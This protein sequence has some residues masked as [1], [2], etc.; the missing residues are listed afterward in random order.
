MV[1]RALCAVGRC[2]A[3]LYYECLWETGVVLRC[4]VLKDL[5]E[6]VWGE[7]RY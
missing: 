6:I 3:S 4:S 7:E 5:C 1:S 2:R